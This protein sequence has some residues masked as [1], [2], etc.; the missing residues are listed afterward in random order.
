[1]RLMSCA[2]LGLTL[3]LLTACATL[4][5]RSDA[6]GVF[7]QGVVLFNQGRYSEAIPLFQRA[8][9][10]DANFGRAY[11]YLGRAYVSL[12]QWLNAIPALRTAF[13]LA[14]ADSQQEITH[15]LLDALLGGATAA[16]KTGNFRDSIG[17]FKEAL[18]VAPQSPSIRLQLVEALL[19]WGGQ[20]LSQ[21]KPADA[22]ATFTE[23]THLAPRHV[24][25]Y[26]GL[27]R[28]LW[29]QGNLL[30]ALAAAQTA[31]SLAP[32]NSGVQALLHQLQGR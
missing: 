18:T 7:D 22:I 19:G 3:G 10:L 8:T 29:Q 26:L 25:A 11:F 27:A 15:L 30:P 32:N 12:G 1:M 4:G 24:E 31:L 9:E 17:L 14:P 16:L 28:A 21:G 23:A 13:H 2:L 6:Q 20:L 5:A